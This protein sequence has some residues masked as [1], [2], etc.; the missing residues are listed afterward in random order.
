MTEKDIEPE[1]NRDLEKGLGQL[2][3]GL[4]DIV[5]TLL[6]NQAVRRY[7]GGHL[8]GEQ[9]RDL[10]HAL[11]LLADTI[12]DLK[13]RFD[14]DPEER[15]S[16][17]LTTSDGDA[18]DLVEALDTLIEKGVVISGDAVLELASVE[19]LALS[20]RVALVSPEKKERAPLTINV[21]KAHH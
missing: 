1:K 8:S 13:S 19:L 2:V 21:D 17:P 10:D 16:L 7:E 5:R 14:L 15:A 9:E 3:V 11:E 4:V 20:L 6:E 12:A 18:L